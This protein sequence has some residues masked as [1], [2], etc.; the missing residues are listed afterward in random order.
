MSSFVSHH[1]P[2]CLPA[3]CCPQFPLATF[4]CGTG[5]MLTLVAD[6]IAASASGHGHGCGGH[7]T[8]Q[9][10]P[11]ADSCCAVEVLAGGCW[12]LAGMGGGWVGGSTSADLLQLGPSLPSLPSSTPAWKA[13][14][15]LPCWHGTL[16]PC[17]VTAP[18]SAAT[19]VD[20]MERGTP[21]GR[22]DKRSSEP[23]AC[24]LLERTPSPSRH[25]A[26]A[27]SNG[28]GTH[29]GRSSGLMGAG[30]ASSTGLPLPG[31]DGSSAF[32]GE[33]Q[34]HISADGVYERS[35]AA[36]AAAAFNG[37]S[38]ADGS[39]AGLLN[40]S[41]EGSGGAGGSIGGVMGG[42][43]SDWR[44]GPSHR[45]SSDSLVF[46]VGAPASSGSPPDGPLLAGGGSGGGNLRSVTFLTAMLMGVALC[47]HS[48]LEGAAMGAQATIRC[49]RGAYTV[50]RG[51]D[52]RGWDP[53]ALLESYG[54]RSRC[55]GLPAALPKH[56]PYPTA[57][58]EPSAGAYTHAPL[59]C[60]PAPLQ[61]L[62]AHLHRDCEPQGAGS[63]RPGQQHCG[64]GGQVRLFA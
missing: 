38:L 16:I 40:L 25:L 12:V 47:F 19:G 13:L 39:G 45:D 14:P 37:G 59:A 52:R 51:G 43:G 31:G 30:R 6:K 55:G 9:R 10:G 24:G 21:G 46:E 58:L 5:Y 49:V 18:S 17:H 11:A 4:L 33:Q 27:R 8:I 57:T 2:A 20:L 15:G 61:Q 32:G 48:L 56:Q 63:L 1:L 62:A 42:S 64:L 54:L 60:L 3:L 34:P 22:L 28:L 29:N 53:A 36:A 26:R 41:K 50:R 35:A 23:E 7:A 44:R